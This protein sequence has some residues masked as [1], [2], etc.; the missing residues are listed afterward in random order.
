[1]SCTFKAHICQCKSDQTKLLPELHGM[2]RNARHAHATFR[3]IA[4]PRPS[5]G[6]PA[7]QQSETN[8]RS[9]GTRDCAGERSTR[10]TSPFLTSQS[11]ATGSD[12]FQSLGTLRKMCQASKHTQRQHWNISTGQIPLTETVCRR[13]SIYSRCP[14]IHDTGRVL[15]AGRRCLS[16]NEPA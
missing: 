8:D 11:A 7:R 14:V 16:S 2:Q 12:P 15:G 5:L 4:S 1:M 9:K 3:P 6:R 10:L 13:E